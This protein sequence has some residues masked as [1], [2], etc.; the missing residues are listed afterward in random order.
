MS[1][2]PKEFERVM[3][4][5]EARKKLAQAAA[6]PIRQAVDSEGKVKVYRPATKQWARLWPVD[7]AEQIRMGVAVL[8]PEPPAERPESSGEADPN[9][10][11]PP[12]TSE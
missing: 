12:A 8:Q 6:K 2:D 3:K 7:A 11:T 9:D 1:V 5:R 10:G 4:E